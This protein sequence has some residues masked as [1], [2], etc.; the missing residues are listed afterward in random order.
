M[1]VIHVH[2]N[3]DH[4]RFEV[5]EADDNPDDFCGSYD[6]YWYMGS[7]SRTV[8]L[9]NGFD[10][11]LNVSFERSGLPF[12]GRIDELSV[13]RYGLDTQQIFDLYHSVPVTAQL[14]LDDRPSS[15]TFD[16]TAVV[17]V[18][19]M[20]PAP[21][22]PARLP[23][24]PLDQ[25]AA[26]FDG[27][28]DQLTIPVENNFGLMASRGVNTTCTNCGIYTLH[29]NGV[30]PPPARSICAPVMLYTYRGIEMCS[31]GGTVSDSQWHHILHSYNANSAT[32]YLDGALINQRVKTRR[33]I[34]SPTAKPNG[35]RCGSDQ[36]IL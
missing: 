21:V 28:D 22:L 33:L 15:N 10:G 14:K 36:T 27:I 2:H 12:A 23:E 17:G 26:R 20:L 3:L 1:L 13:Y 9:S 6:T 34:R 24:P 30:P 25:S 7:E 8:S 32:L 29:A 19:M 4:L 11:R 35:I 31:T 18:K 16:N 5:W